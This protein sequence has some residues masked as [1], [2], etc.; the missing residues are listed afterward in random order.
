MIKLE[1]ISFCGINFGNS[2]WYSHAR[3]CDVCKN[4]IEKLKL[5][6]KTL[7]DNWVIKCAC[8]CDKITKYGNNFI[9]GHSQKGVKQSKRHKEN[10]LNSWVD[11]GNSEKYSEEWKTNNPSS[12]DKNRKRLKEN[13]PATT[14]EVRLKISENNPMKIQKNI[15]KI[16]ETKLERYNDENYNNQE[17]F[18]KTFLDKYGVDNPSKVKD[19]LEKRISTYTTRLSNGDYKTKNNWVCGYYDRID[20]TRE[21]YD[22]SYELIK[23]KEYDDAK[24]IWTKKHGIKIPF[25]KNNGVNSYYVPDFLINNKTIV[26]VKGWLK[27]DDILKAK[28]AIMWCMTNGYEYHFL[29]GDKMEIVTE[30]SLIKN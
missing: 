15:D 14:D 17:L 13:N 4:E 23:M 5:I 18:K 8:G 22:S 9:I 7:K 2:T 1:E 21:W 20:G 6:E 16:K 11:N 24:M 30:L 12:T 28:T 27:K 29:L 3:K 26:E 10:R 19:I 25:I